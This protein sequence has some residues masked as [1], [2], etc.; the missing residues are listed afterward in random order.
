MN[1]TAL[2]F[3]PEGGNV[4]RVTIQLGEVI[5]NEKVDIIPAKDMVKEDLHKYSQIIFVCST[6][7][8][9][10]WTN[11]IYVDEWQEFFRKIE[12]ISFEGKKVAIVGLGNSVLYPEHFADGIAHL[13][14]KIANKNA[15][16]YGFVDAE[17]YTF[18]DSEALNED[19]LFYG[20]PIDEENEYDQTSERLENWIS[21][22]KSDFEF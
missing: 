14:K 17:G 12:E 18:N 21:K 8:A 3:S 19:G 22:L 4:N 5:G 9:D 16:I 15:N 7:G 2:F 10:H 1:K 13:H 6:V 20:L 11:E